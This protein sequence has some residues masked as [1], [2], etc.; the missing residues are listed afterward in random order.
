VG[1]AVGAG[2]EKR[3]IWQRGKEKVTGMGKFEWKM[4][5]AE[6]ESEIEADTIRNE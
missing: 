3:V 5:G 2:R 1:V 4:I 6:R